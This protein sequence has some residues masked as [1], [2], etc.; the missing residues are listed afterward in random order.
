MVPSS[1]T[2]MNAAAVFG[3]PGLRSKS[4]LPLNTTPVG[5]ATKQCGGAFLA[6]QGKVPFG[7]GIVTTND[8]AAPVPSY[9]VETPAL[10]SPIHQ[11]LVVLRASPHEFRRLLSV[12]AAGMPEL[13]FVTRLVWT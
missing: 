2:K 7:P 1:V 12:C 8:L 5:A 11:G 10:L 6:V 9:N 4:G 3:S 13:G